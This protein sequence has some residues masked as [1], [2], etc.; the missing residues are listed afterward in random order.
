MCSRSAAASRAVTRL[1]SDADL[2]HG[3][4]GLPGLAGG[5]GGEV[6]V[7]DEQSGVAINADKLA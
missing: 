2:L 6:F 4:S 5:P 7:F 3:G 1:F